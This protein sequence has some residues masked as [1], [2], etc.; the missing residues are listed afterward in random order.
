MISTRYDAEADAMYVRIA[1]DDTQVAE[2]REIEAGV[3]L[4]M[5]EAGRLIGIEILGV[6]ARSAPN[7]IAA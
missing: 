6:H 4:D 1:P 7:V 3:M 2:T 5:D